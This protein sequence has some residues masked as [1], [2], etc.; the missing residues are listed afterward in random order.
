MVIMA[1]MPGCLSEESPPA[2]LPGSVGLVGV[3]VGYT[4]SS[5]FPPIPPEPDGFTL[6]WDP[7]E[8]IRCY[9]VR[10]SPLPID[11]A[12]W[13]DAL[14]VATVDGRSPTDSVEVFVQPEVISN[15]CTGCGLCELACPHDAITI[16]SGGKAVIDTELCT[17]CGECYR[18]CPFDAV[19]NSSYGQP[20]HFAV[21]AIAESGAVSEVSCTS[22]RYYMRYTNR[23]PWCGDC[24]DECFILLDSCGPGCPV[25]AVWFEDSTSDNP[26][27]VHIDYDKCIQC[28]QCMVQCHEYGLLSIRREVVEER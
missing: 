19:T 8:S 14:L 18:A 16:S 2:D 12:N 1:G 21:R 5:F 4:D 22:S 17:Q 23:E 15:A 24:F 13:D 25:D 26:G 7:V 27:L 11:A 20:Y 28:G 10:I 6:S 3:E 9:Q